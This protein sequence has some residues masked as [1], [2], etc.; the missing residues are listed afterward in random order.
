[1]RQ[2][3]S[4]L[5]AKW[6]AAFGLPFDLTF[7]KPPPIASSFK[8]TG[9]Y[10]RSTKVSGIFSRYHSRKWLFEAEQFYKNFEDSEHK[11]NSNGRF[12]AP[13]INCGHFFGCSIVA[14]NAEA[15]EYGMNPEEQALLEVEMDLDNLLDLRYEENIDW[16]L[17]QV[18]ENPELLGNSYFVKLIEL[19]H[20]VQGG[21]VVNERIGHIARKAGYDGILWFGARALR[22]F[23][24]DWMTNPEDP[25]IFD[26]EQEAFPRMREDLDLQNIVVFSG[27]NVIRSIRQYRIDDGAWKPNPLF[28]ISSEEL[29][30][31]LE[32]PSSY[33]AQQGRQL[34][35]GKIRLE[36]TDT[37][38]AVQ[39]WN[40]NRPGS[41]QG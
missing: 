37:G 30:K 5:K 2:M 9:K 26:I 8:Q 11:W 3:L 23:E 12:A 15:R 21:D 16:M 19:I 17:G 40:A 18:Y 33:Q 28:A 4:W 38:E 7:E 20:H 29:D 25:M 34:L 39:F 36:P 1:M 24:T 31:V 6:D 22:D 41:S 10:E 35:A 27:A 13:D 32:F 14:T